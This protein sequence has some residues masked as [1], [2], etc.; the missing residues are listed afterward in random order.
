MF[1]YN[2][3]VKEDWFKWSESLSKED[4]RA[5]KVGVMG[6]IIKNLIHIIDYEL[7]WVNHMLNLLSLFLLGRL[8][9]IQELNQGH[10]ITQNYCHF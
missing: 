4:L 2:W 3:Q 7:I 1:L 6:S 10:Y 5:E 8:S 9:H